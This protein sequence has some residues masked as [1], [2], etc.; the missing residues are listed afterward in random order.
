MTRPARIASCSS[1]LSKCVRQ[2]ILPS[3]EVGSLTL[4]PTCYKSKKNTLTSRPLKEVYSS[5]SNV[6]WWTNNPQSQF[7]YDFYPQI[8]KTEYIT[9]LSGFSVHMLDF[10]RFWLLNRSW[11]I[12]Y[13]NEMA[14]TPSEAADVIGDIPNGSW[15]SLRGEEIMRVP[16]NLKGL[17]GY[18]VGS[19]P[20]S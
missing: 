15:P 12:I 6:S 11:L 16:F 20:A 13:T 2:A 1:S 7:W 17:S 3:I 8:S 14:T 5:P 4:G 9:P 18:L 10:R 19:S